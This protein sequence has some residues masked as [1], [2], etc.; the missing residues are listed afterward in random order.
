[1]PRNE[2]TRAWPSGWLGRDVVVPTITP[3][4][5]VTVGRRGPSAANTVRRRAKQRKHRVSPTTC[6]EAMISFD[7]SKGKN[8]LTPYQGMRVTFG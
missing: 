3:L 8:Y 2:L 7:L 6:E 4:D 5:I 1:M